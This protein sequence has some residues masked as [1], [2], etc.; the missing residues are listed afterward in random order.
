[1][2]RIGTDLE[3]V[4]PRFS[5]VVRA[6]LVVQGGEVLVPEGGGV[7]W[8]GCPPSTSQ[9]SALDVR[10]FKVLPEGVHCGGQV[11]LRLHEAFLDVIGGHERQADHLP[12]AVTH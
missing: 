10:C 7:P 6:R 1:M 4:V 2:S 5:R 11:V 8:R 9:D 12:E 3:S